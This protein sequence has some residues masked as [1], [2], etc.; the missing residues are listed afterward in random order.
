MAIGEIDLNLKEQFKSQASA[1]RN[2]AA[3][4]AAKY[5]LPLPRS[6]LNIDPPN[7]DNRPDGTKI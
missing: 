6:A 4:R 1:Y 7:I 2:L 5:D 3:D